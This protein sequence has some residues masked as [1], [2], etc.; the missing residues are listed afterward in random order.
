MPRHVRPIT[1]SRMAALTTPRLLAYKDRLMRLEETAESSDCVA[2]EVA[3]LDPERVYFKSDPRW[4]D[5]LRT[6]KA[7]LAHRGHGTG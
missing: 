3:K 7:L 1:A 4:R 6:V 5:L 2:D